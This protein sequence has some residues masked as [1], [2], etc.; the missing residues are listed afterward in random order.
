MSPC[1]MNRDTTYQNLDLRMSVEVGIDGGGAA[2]R[3]VW[4]VLGR[5]PR[6]CSGYSQGDKLITLARI[7]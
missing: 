3:G 5:Y 1:F 2:L 7:I 6:E 4:L